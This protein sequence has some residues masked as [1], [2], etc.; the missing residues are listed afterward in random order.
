MATQTK[1]ISNDWVKIGD[2]SHTLIILQ[3]A[4][5]GAF[6]YFLTRE[7]TAPSS[8]Q[9]GFFHRR[10]EAI[11]FANGGVNVYIRGAAGGSA[12]IVYFVA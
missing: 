9:D 1:Q 6:E 2:T 8:D 5:M 3:A 11:T 7:S 10:N 4:G 12:N